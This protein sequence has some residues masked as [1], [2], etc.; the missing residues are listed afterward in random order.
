MTQK[1]KVGTAPAT[2]IEAALRESEQR[3]RWLASIIESSDDAIASKNLMV[4]LQAGIVVP[5][6]SSATLPARQ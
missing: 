2:E 4:L 5:S 6:A 1:N 3:L